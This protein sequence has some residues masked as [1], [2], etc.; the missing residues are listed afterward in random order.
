M[1]YF[2]YSTSITMLA[3]VALILATPKIPAI[4]RLLFIFIM[5]G[6]LLMMDFYGIQH[7]MYPQGSQPLDE[8]SVVRELYLAGKW[9]LPFL[10][11]I[12]MVY[13]YVGAF[14]TREQETE[15]SAQ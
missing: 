14:F 3:F 4:R 11:W 5:L 1:G 2:I 7:I 8:D 12:V 9:I 13:P 15:T 10:I 6:A